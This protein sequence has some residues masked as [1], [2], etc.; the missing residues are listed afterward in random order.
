MFVYIAEIYTQNF[1]FLNLFNYIT[2]RTGAA[3]LTSLFFSLIF[4]EKIINFL[5]SLQPKGQPIRTDGPER[6]I[7]EKAGTP[8]EE[9]LALAKQVNEIA[10]SES[11]LENGADSFT[12]IGNANQQE[13]T[14]SDISG[15]SNHS[16]YF[17]KK[18]LLWYL[19]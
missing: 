9:F 14:F 12:I 2:F 5:S 19:D 4:G 17:F 15:S 1:T 8:T 11:V 16:V 18:E 6:Y 13:S 10:G 7:F 3:I